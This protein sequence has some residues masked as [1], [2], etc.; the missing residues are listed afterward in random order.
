MV[1][2][3]ALPRR[4]LARLGAAAGVVYFVVIIAAGISFLLITNLAIATSLGLPQSP[5]SALIHKPLWHLGFVFYCLA[6]RWEG[7]GVIVLVFVIE[8]LSLGWP[9]SSLRRVL[10][11]K[12]QSTRY[13]IAL[14]V[15]MR[16][17]LLWGYL[18]SVFSLGLPYL[19][20]LLIRAVTSNV[21][22]TEYRFRTGS[23]ALDVLVYYFVF[24]FFAY[25]N[26]RL[27]HTG[28]FWPLHRMH[29]S[30]TELNLLTSSRNHPAAIA[31]EP[32]IRAWPTVLIGVPPDVIMV[33]SMIMSTWHL[34]IHSML[35]WHLSWFGQWLM[36][37]PIGHRIHH[38]PLPEHAGKNLSDCPL[39]DQLF[40]T[41]YSGP[42]L[43]TTVGVSEDRPPTNM[44]KEWFTDLFAFGRSVIR[45]ARAQ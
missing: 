28:L 3:S 45:A 35:P 24:T 15:L 7:I 6:I 42:V 37:S 30:A 13:D 26:H 1:L 32:F 9:R 23:L 44:V 2:D 4:S 25:W 31:I 11:P 36:V 33:Y 16:S 39:W 43:N 20:A 17:S 8:A 10:I 27:F 5:Y 19:S 34:L 14:Y 18:M 22:P 38:S 41:W 12:A 29:H 40:G 21:L